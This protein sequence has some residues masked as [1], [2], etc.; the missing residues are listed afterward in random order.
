MRNFPMNGLKNAGGASPRIVTL[1]LVTDSLEA[2]MGAGAYR[3]RQVGDTLTDIGQ[4]LEGIT[5]HTKLADRTANFSFKLRGTWSLD[6]ISWN[7]FAAD[8]VTV[9]ANGQS[10]TA[11]YTTRT[12]FGRQIRFEFGT[13]DAGAVEHGTCSVVVALKFYVSAQRDPTSAGAAPTAP[14]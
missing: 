1:D 6:G 14:A 12:D 8:L 11:E 5:V 10:I 3:W 9:A 2:T 13:S 4:R 7:V